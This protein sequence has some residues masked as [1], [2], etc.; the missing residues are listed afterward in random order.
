MRMARFV[1][2]ATIIMC[3]CMVLRGSSLRMVASVNDLW[4]CGATIRIRRSRMSCSFRKVQRYVRLG[5]L[6]GIGLW[7]YMRE[8][9]VCFQ[10]IMLESLE[11]CDIEIKLN[12]YA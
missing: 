11:G 8:Q 2:L 1:T 7:V 5:I 9:R 3:S 4:L 6:M 12:S 10:A